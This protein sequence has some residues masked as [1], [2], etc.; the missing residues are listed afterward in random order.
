MCVPASGALSVAGAKTAATII[1][2]KIS[3]QICRSIQW[4]TKSKETAPQETSL[5]PARPL[6]SCSSE[7]LFLLWLFLSRSLTQDSM[8]LSNFHSLSTIMYFE[9]TALQLHEAV[10]FTTYISE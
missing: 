6:C 5:F 9:D 10:L 3:K 2:E 1:P 7:R 4:F 8:L